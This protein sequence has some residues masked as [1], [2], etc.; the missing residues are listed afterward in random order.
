MPSKSTELV[1][2]DGLWAPNW[3]ASVRAMPPV[4]ALAPRERI[5]A[6]TGLLRSQST[7]LGGW[8][9][10]LSACGA[11]RLERSRITHS[12]Q[13]QRARQHKTHT[14]RWATDELF[15]C[16]S[17]RSEGR[18]SHGRSGRAAGVGG[19]K[20]VRPTCTPT[21]R[22][23]MGPAG[24]AWGPRPAARPPMTTLAS[25]MAAPPRRWRPLRAARGPT[26]GAQGGPVHFRLFRGL[27]R[28]PTHSKVVP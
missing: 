1:V 2:R 16:G 14:P 25:T 6:I 24:G 12:A 19:Q 23:G 9:D 11:C 26:E 7:Q 18:A 10:E 4:W 27:V 20:L 17:H 21:P 22:G 3:V 5:L 8:V 15:A 28:P 13:V